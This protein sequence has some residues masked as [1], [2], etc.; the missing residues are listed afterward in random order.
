MNIKKALCSVALVACAF[1]MAQGK[2]YEVKSPNGELTAKIE[3]GAVLRYSLF[4]DGAPVLEDCAIGMDTDKGQ[5]G[6]D[7]TVK[8]VSEEAVDT[9]QAAF[10]FIKSEIRDV[11]REATLN[12]GDY[13]LVVRVYDDALAYRFVTR[14]G[15]GAMLVRAETAEFRFPDEALSWVHGSGGER[16]CFEEQVKVRTVGKLRDIYAAGLPFIVQSGKAKV[17]VLESDVLSYP[18]LRVA[19]NKEKNCPQGRFSRYP[20]TFKVEGRLI[21]GDEFEEGI[22]RTTGSRAFPWRILQIAREDKDFLASDVVYKLATPSRIKDTGWI[23]HGVCVWDWMSRNQLRG[24]DFDPGMNQQSVN[25]F[26]DFAAKFGITFSLVDDGWIIGDGIRDDSLFING[27]RRI[28]IKAAAD[29]AHG[30]GVKFLVWAMAKNLAY[31]PEESFRMMADYGVDGM[32]IDFIER[33][34]QLA[35][36]LYENFARLGA[37][38]KMVVFYHGCS[39]PTGMNRTYPNILNYESVGGNEFPDNMSTDHNIK[40]ALTRNLAG[41]MDYTPGIMTSSQ[42]RGKNMRDMLVANGTRSGQMAL[43]VLFYAPIQMICDS[44]TTYEAEPEVTRF[45]AGIPTVWDET[46]GLDSRFDEYVTVARRKGKV[47]YVAGLRNNG[48]HEWKLKLSGFLEAGKKYRVDAY[49]DTKNSHKIGMDFKHEVLEV[50]GRGTMEFPVA[51]NGG[52]VMRFS[53]VE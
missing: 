32:K 13:A 38:H 48:N 46:R 43:F 30:K 39:R 5:L 26:I 17:A 34:D 35:N 10:N 19:Y 44:P 20:R 51:N 53:P 12:F 4:L 24:V 27:K 8:E 25:Y 49:H 1:A 45:L 29:Y 23:P 9:A 21:L 14:F 31:K 41:P 11:C 37:K 36:E 40:T 33:D 52:F 47:W 3:D 7:A 50:S 2:V 15:D 42:D 6:V 28:D 18:S 22:A 16:A